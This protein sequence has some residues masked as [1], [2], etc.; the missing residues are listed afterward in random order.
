M[1]LGQGFQPDAPAW[2]IVLPRAA[3]T[4]KSRPKVQF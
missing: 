1:H 2:M 4:K 3:L